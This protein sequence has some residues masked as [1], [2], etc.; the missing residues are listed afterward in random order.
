MKN[1]RGVWEIATKCEW[2]N[3]YL[4]PDEPT[5]IPIVQ[6]FDLELKDR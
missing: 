2:T 1:C 3:F 4:P 5:I 6:E